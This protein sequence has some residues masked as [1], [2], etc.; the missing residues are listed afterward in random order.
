MK[1]KKS[2]DAH[3]AFEKSAVPSPDLIKAMLS[4]AEARKIQGQHVLPSSGPMS[5]NSLVYWDSKVKQNKKIHFQSKPYIV[6]TTN[7]INS[8]LH[9]EA[10]ELPA[11]D[12]GYY[13]RGASAEN[14]GQKGQ[15]FDKRLDNEG[16]G[17]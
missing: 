15:K 7:Q 12:Y 14:Q 13:Q 4:Q 17:D 6:Q 9:P 11:R 8:D 10:S 16:G 2:P 1:R 3:P 5:R